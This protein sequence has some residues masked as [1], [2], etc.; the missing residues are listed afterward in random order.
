MSRLDA[1]TRADGDF[2]VLPE[3]AS[4]QAALVDMQDVKFCDGQKWQ[5]QQWRADRHNVPLDLLEFESRFINRARNMYRIPLYCH[6]A[7]RSKADQLKLVEEGRS[8][9][10]NGPHVHGLA[11]DIIHSTKA[12]NLSKNQWALLGHI[13]KE[14]AQT[15]H[16][17]L[18]WGGDWRFYDP[19]HWEI[20]QWRL[21]VKK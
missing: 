14:V 5:E 19:A 11:L 12:W 20:A 10:P 3:D 21:R 17:K 16:I 7:R 2:P 13:G 4:L 6:T 1:E 15:L 18:D 8:R 9:D